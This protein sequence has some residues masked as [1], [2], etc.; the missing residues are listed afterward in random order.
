MIRYLY[1]IIIVILSINE[2]QAQNN[3]LELQQ[4]R[5]K[6]Q[7][8]ELL[9]TPQEK[10][11]DS[12]LHLN[13]KTIEII[14][15]YKFKNARQ[16]KKYDQL[17]VDVLKTYPLALVVGSELKLVNTE[18]DSIYTEP[19]RRK[20]YLKWY[21]DYVKNTYMDSLKNLDVKQG[22]LLLKLIHRETGQSPYELLKAY[23][24]RGNAIFWQAM[25]FSLGANLKSEY[26]P[27]EDGMIEHII[28]RY[29]A[30]EF[31]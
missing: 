15:P 8:E 13:L 27:E 11:K 1:I 25:A 10:K 22:K 16:E 23:R 5:E 4:K 17:T 28:R 14:Q 6:A 31:N 18:L 7:Q 24:G 9:F 20:A 12:I 21:Q 30:G 29:N 2:L 19:K 26:D 3:R